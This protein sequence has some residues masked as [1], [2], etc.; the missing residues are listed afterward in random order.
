MKKSLHYFVA[1]IMFVFYT[2]I[3]FGQCTPDPLVTDP[4]GN[5]EMVPDTLEVWENE[6]VGLTLTVIAPDTASVGTMGHINLHHITVK[7]L[8]NAPS[9]LA[10]T[11]TPSNC[12]FVGTESRCV[13]VSGSSVTS[14]PG[15]YPVDVIVDVY[16]TI[17]GSAVLV[18][19]NYNSGTPLIIWVHPAGW[20]V[21]ERA[22]NGFGIREAKPNPFNNTVKIGCYTEG[23]QNV[24]L[25][26]M[27]MVGNEVYNEVLNAGAGESYFAFD[28]SG[29]SNGLYFYSLIDEQNRVI[30]KKFVKTK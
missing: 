5:G 12:E 8:N 11:C 7:S 29:L 19:S 30:T 25:K 22:F 2:G 3:A 14:A 17:L 28:G 9:W 18:Q 27:D 24:T 10:Y 15:F 26:V 21:T 16:A 13:W 4:E 6:A 20:G 23:A 1:C